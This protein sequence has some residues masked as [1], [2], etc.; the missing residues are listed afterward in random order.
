MEHDIPSSQASTTI[1]NVNTSCVEEVPICNCIEDWNNENF[2]NY[3]LKQNTRN[4]LVLRTVKNVSKARRKRLRQQE[5]LQF[6]KDEF[7]FVRNIEKLRTKNDSRNVTDIELPMHE[8]L[9][10]SEIREKFQELNIS[11]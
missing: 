6:C 8:H 2:E 4:R 7:L 10:L 1:P 9:N 5:R 11:H 3:D